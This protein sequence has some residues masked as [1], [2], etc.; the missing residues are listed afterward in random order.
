[1][2]VV[3]KGVGPQSP[4]GSWENRNMQRSDCTTQKRVG[5][6]S[7]HRGLAKWIKEFGDFILK[8]VESCLKKKKKNLSHIRFFK[9]RSACNVKHDLEENKTQQEA[10]AIV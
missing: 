5:K 6:S 3:P 8:T 9:D 1:M 10:R 4:S 7:D 2:V